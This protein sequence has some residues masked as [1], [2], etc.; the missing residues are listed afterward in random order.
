MEVWRSVEGYSDYWIS[1]EGRIWSNK[2]DTY[3]KPVLDPR[4]G[5]LRAKF[6]KNNKPK[7]IALHKLVLLTFKGPP[8]DDGK[9]YEVD[10]INRIKSDNRLCNLRYLT[11]S[12]NQY[13]AQLFREDGTV[14]GVRWIKKY[15]YKR[16]CYNATL[17]ETIEKHFIPKIDNN[18]FSQDEAR[19]EANKFMMDQIINLGKHDLRTYR[20]LT[21]SQKLFY[22]GSEDYKA[23]E[24]N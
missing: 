4:K 10:H 7:T 16:Y 17:H 22:F 1:S 3:L 6:S 12:D 11:T 13:N 14:L 24:N 15:K 20:S 19:I 23:I 2:R 5:Y 18:E 21:K 8:P 9:Y